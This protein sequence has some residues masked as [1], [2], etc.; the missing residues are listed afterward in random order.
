MSWLQSFFVAVLTAVVAAIA[1]GWIGVLCVS[2]YRI[3]PREGGSGYFV[4]A[5][6]VLSGF[7]GFLL[8]FIL[9]RYFGG[10]GTAGFFTG[11]GASAGAALGL[12]GA[13]T[14]I[15]WR[16]ADIPPTIH[17]HELDLVVEARLP[18]GAERPAVIEGKQFVFFESGERGKA[19]R[20]SETGFLDVSKTTQIEG[21][22]VVPGSVRIFTTRDTR[23]VTIALD[24]KRAFGFELRFPG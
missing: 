12:A 24:E 1:G 18:V 21:R 22:W 17:G 7:L 8:G 20:A 23:F 9:S 14:V 19:P 10:A 4:A 13:I 6:V 16:L 11:L 3:S 5:I 2:W 15:A